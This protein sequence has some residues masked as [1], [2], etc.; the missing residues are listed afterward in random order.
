M[1]IWSITRVICLKYR[2]VIIIVV[3]VIVRRVVCQRMLF[4]WRW[5]VGLLVV[6]IM[7]LLGIYGIVLL[8]VV[9]GVEGVMLLEF[10]VVTIRV[11]YILDGV[12]PFQISVSSRARFHHQ[13]LQ[14]V[15]P[16][17]DHLECFVQDP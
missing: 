15:V 4:M 12:L 8:V 9:G 2:L 7:M 1:K 5:L 14:L 17:T 6:L 13:N 11:V 3:W 10:L 16:A